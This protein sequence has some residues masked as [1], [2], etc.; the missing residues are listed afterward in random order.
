V[1][2][3]VWSE[4]A[5]A[6]LEAIAEYVALENPAAAVAL[7]NRV[8]RHVDQ[9]SRH[10][11]SGSWLPELGRT[12]YRQIVEPPCRVIYRRAGNRVAILHVMRTE[13]L[14]DMLRLIDADDAPKP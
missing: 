4:P 11:Q 7:L 1:A 12:R 8:L 6:D 9:L 3:V 14:L 2:Q 5:R 13:R 10:P